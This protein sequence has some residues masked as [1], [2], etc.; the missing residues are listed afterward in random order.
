MTFNR[1]N[2]FFIDK[3][4]SDSKI[5]AMDGDTS[6]TSTAAMRRFDTDQERLRALMA[7]VARRDET[8]LVELYD[9]TISRVFAIAQRITRQTSTAEEVVSDVYLQV[10]Q[11]SENYDVRRG[12][13]ITWLLTIC[14]SRAI[15][16][17]RR[18][19]RAILHDD[20]DTLRLDIADTKH[21]PLALVE[22]M[23]TNSAMRQALE[24]LTRREQ[25]LISLAFF[26]GL[27]HQEI[28]EQTNTPL[29]TVK[30]IIRNALV[31]LREQLQP[32]SLT[33]DPA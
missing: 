28:A 14:R 7:R 13:V 16:A 10:W 15:D 1:R 29:G 18:R 26:R 27:T 32:H 33:E 2:A 25:Y 17:L 22:S 9:L 5:Y 4:Q 21:E 31:S 24:S 11:L 8:A 3:R 30:S 23:E 12:S 20:P 19:D 6:L